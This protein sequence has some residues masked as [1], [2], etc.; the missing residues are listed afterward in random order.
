MKYFLDTEFLDDG[1]TID[2]IS[3]GIVA[4]DGRELYLESCEFNWLLATQWLLDNVKPNLT[5]IE[6]G[7]LNYIRF[8]ILDFLANDNN[9]EFWGYYSSYDWVVFCQLF[10]RMID[11][12]KSLPMFCND[13]KQELKRL[14]LKIRQISSNHN[15][16]DDAKWIKQTYE[17]VVKDREVV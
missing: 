6:P 3:I 2:L 9:I 17:A 1:K 14:G 12:P 16:L 7:K 15:A 11:L 5:A 8:R 10:G 13:L 4:E